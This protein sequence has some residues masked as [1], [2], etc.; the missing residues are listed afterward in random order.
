M[1]TDG[2]YRLPP[3]ERTERLRALAGAALARWG[4]SGGRAP[5][6]VKCRENAVFRVTAPDGRRA[7]LRIHR[8]GYH[9]DAAL[10]SELA[11]MEALRGAGV[12]VPAVVP[13]S[14]GAP[15]A[16]V[17]ARGVPEPRQV[18]MVT[19]MTGAPLGTIEDGPG[20]AVADLRA[21]FRG[22]G[23]LAARLHNHAQGWS[24]PAG[25]VRH[26]WDEAGL[27]GA[28]PLWG[29]FWLD[30]GL[31][32]PE[33]RLIERARDRARGDLAA[34]GRPPRRYG[35]IHADF[36]LDNMLLDGDR[37]VLLD[38]DDS[39]FGWHLFDLATVWTLFHGAD[40]AAPM[41]AGVIEGYRRERDLP[42]A[43]VARLPL[44]EL[45]RA[46]SYLGWVGTRRETATARAIAP[47][48]AALAC[49]LAEAYLR[50]PVTKTG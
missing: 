36:N 29:R 11:W 15:F 37:V 1:A 48:V 21:T 34:Y 45:A 20:P 22:V 39:G 10:R 8:H 41:R 9:T 42:D 18:D 23:R 19:W 35:L 46:F 38:F 3:A 2:F 14:S 30:G 4:V 6:V 24:S 44:F 7:A 31:G 25:F 47:R 12:A 33:R 43:E 28:D 26:A 5:E 13:T 40:C 16:V 50:R 17:R 32:A 27:L 49:E